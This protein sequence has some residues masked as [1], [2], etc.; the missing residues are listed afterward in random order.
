MHSTFPDIAGYGVCMLP[1]PKAAEARILEIFKESETEDAELDRVRQQSELVD[2]P[3]PK[4]EVGTQCS[5]IS[6]CDHDRARQDWY[7]LI[8]MAMPTRSV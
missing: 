7:N 8:W 2:L 3:V 6:Q 4:R 5:A 1:D